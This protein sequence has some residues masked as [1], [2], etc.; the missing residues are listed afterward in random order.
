MMNKDVAFAIT[1]AMW[2]LLAASQVMYARLGYSPLPR[3]M[4]WFWG[5]LL[6]FHGAIFVLVIL[7]ITPEGK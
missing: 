7:T 6:C 5:A 4:L 1:T 2:V 3:F